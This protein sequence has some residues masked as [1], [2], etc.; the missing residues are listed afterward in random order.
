M[1]PP[2][3][4]TEADVEAKLIHALLRDPLQL[5]IPE[6]NIRDKEFLQPTAL[7]KKA[8]RTSGYI[9]DYAVSI[10]ALPLLIVEAKSPDTD[11]EV[12]YRE[13][14]LYAFHLNKQ[15]KANVNP[16]QRI[17]ATNGKRILAGPWDSAPTVDL[18]VRDLVTGGAGL[19]SLKELCGFPALSAVY[20]KVAP[21]L[22]PRNTTFPYS[23]SGGNALLNAKK[24]PNTFAAPL[25][26]VLKRYFSSKQQNTDREIY[27]VAYVT[28]DEITSY[29]DIAT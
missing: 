8:G 20:T 15:F 17:L 13:A 7:D 3:F 24:A 2:I 1:I 11:P 22:R 27:E 12:G 4:K 14:G 9:P 18:K 19:T 23:L 21:S 6:E 28:S 5:G 25:S 10:G 16:C 29:D 26:P